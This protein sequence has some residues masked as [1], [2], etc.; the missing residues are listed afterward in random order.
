M[1]SPMARTMGPM[2]RRCFLSFLFALFSFLFLSPQRE[3]QVPLAA[4]CAAGQTPTHH[5]HPPPPLPKKGLCWPTADLLATFPHSTAFSAFQST[6]SQVQRWMD[7]EC[8]GMLC[9]RALL[10]K[11]F[12]FGYACP[13]RCTLKGRGKK[14]ITH[15]DITSIIIILKS[16]SDSLNIWIPMRFFLLSCPCFLACWTLCEKL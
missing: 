16:T 15:T 14:E 2:D 1:G 6:H 9:R 3:Q 12:F 11:K 4:A 7:L 5:H 13:I 8:P 10:K